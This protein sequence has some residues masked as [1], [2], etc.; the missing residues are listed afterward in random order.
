MRLKDLFESVEKTKKSTT[1]I[2]KMNG[3]VIR[4]ED[5]ESGEVVRP[6]AKKKSI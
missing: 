5:Y 6:T 3:K 2:G 4:K 1:V